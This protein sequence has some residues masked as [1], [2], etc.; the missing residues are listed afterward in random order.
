ME[1]GPLKAEF[2]A[3]GRTDMTKL[4]VSFRNFVNSPALDFFIGNYE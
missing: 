4:T 3:D 1:F 2:H